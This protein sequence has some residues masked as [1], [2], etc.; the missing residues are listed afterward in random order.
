M[1]LRVITDSVQSILKVLLNPFLWRNW[2]DDLKTHVEIQATQN[3]KNSPEKERNW[4]THLSRF[5]NLLRS[6]AS[7]EI[8]VLAWPRHKD[9][10]NRTESP[11]INSD[12]YGQVTADKGAK[13]MPRENLVPSTNSAETI[14]P[15]H[16]TNH[17]N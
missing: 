17:K 1:L 3:R 9:Q 12:I 10:S 15:L 11:E 4:R 16:H 14:E 8:A 7:Q 2:Q 13:T 5:Q 6:C